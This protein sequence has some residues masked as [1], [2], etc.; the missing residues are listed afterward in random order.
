M[1]LLNPEEDVP[2]PGKSGRRQNENDRINAKV[3]S[4]RLWRQACALAPT[5]RPN[6]RPAF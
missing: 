3:V 2:V 1:R 5:I 6:Q 4:S